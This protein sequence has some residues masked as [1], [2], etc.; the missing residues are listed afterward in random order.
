[1]P[2]PLGL[3]N[4]AASLA[5]LG[6]RTKLDVDN[7]RVAFLHRLLDQDAP[8]IAAATADKHFVVFTMRLPFS[9]A[10][11]RTKAIQEAL[12]ALNLGARVCAWSHDPERGW[13]SIRQSVPIHHVEYS[14]AAVA[15]IVQALVD[16]AGREAPG[17]S[18]L[19]S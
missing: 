14:D 16:E 12:A 13:V 11:A 19:A 15:A 2:F 9:V 7:R 6:L 18:A 4:L 17:L 10:A 1:V 5:R 3:D 8:V